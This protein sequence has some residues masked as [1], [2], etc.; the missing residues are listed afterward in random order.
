MPLLTNQ[1]SVFQAELIKL[2]RAFHMVQYVIMWKDVRVCCF[3]PTQMELSVRSLHSN[4]DDYAESGECLSI[5]V[6]TSWVLLH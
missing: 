4:P 2:H 5:I 3:P 1:S 6:F